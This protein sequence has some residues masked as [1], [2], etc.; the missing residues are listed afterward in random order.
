[1]ITNS[2]QKS[3]L[4]VITPPPPVHSR[5]KNKLQSIYSAQRPARVNAVCFARFVLMQYLPYFDD[6]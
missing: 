6:G 1:M 4:V 5:L 3:E 2:L